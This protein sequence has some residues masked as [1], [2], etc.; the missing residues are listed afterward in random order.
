MVDIKQAIAAAKAYASEILGPLD[1]LVEEVTSE[2]AV[3]HITLSFTARTR[4]RRNDG[5]NLTDWTQFHADGRE[6]KEFAVEKATG[7]VRKMSIRQIA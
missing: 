3:F 4:D 5:K 2:D 1:F 7:A 6:Y